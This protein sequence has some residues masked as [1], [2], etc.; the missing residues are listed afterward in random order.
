MPVGTSVETDADRTIL[1]DGLN[2]SS[3]ALISVFRSP[4]SSITMTRPRRFNFF[5]I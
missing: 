3:L 5:L 2:E 4:V 1:G